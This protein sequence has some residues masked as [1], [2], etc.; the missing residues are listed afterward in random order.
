MNYLTKEEERIIGALIEK[1]FTTPE[2]Y[3]L[4]LN[5]L[6]NA[7]N[8][9]SNRE[10]IVDYNESIIESNLQS[11]SEKKLV[12]KVT[13]SDFRVPKYDENFC[14]LFNL[15]IEETAVMCVL[16]LRGPQTL[17]EIRNRSSRIHQFENL[18]DAEKTLQKIIS[19]KTNPVFIS[20]LLRKPGKDP[21]YA[22]I[23]SGE[24]KTINEE[25]VEEDKIAKLENELRDIRE[26]LEKLKAEFLSLKNQFE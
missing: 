8:Q 19:E 3:P 17:G 13:G 2:Y 12:F 23:L 9:K 20:K 11:L 21:R 6:K 5:S 14:G 1:K 15:T 7:C 4:T 10:P 25:E 24:T 18:M 26:E 16:M 22:C